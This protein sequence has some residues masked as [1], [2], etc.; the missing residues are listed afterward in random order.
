MLSC[1]NTTYTRHYIR[2]GYLVKLRYLFIGNFLFRSSKLF[3]KVTKSMH[4]N[5][6]NSNVSSDNSNMV[7]ST[8]N[9][10]EGKERSGMMTSRK[11]RRD[12]RDYLEPEKETD[13]PTNFS[14][15]EQQI[16]IAHKKAVEVCNFIS[17][18]YR[19]KPCIYVFT[20][21]ALVYA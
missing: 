17:M 14:E 1:I 19:R 4:S 10:V 6:E 11:E 12:G 9:P 3:I 5:D 2:L 7:A 20:T 13:M 15:M 18:I 8:N 21:P 16:F